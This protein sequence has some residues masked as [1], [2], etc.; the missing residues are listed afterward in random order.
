MDYKLAALELR[1]LAA[2][3]SCPAVV[4][5]AALALADLHDGRAKENILEL[6]ALLDIQKADGLPA[7][8]KSLLEGLQKVQDWHSE[9]VWLAGRA[10][11]TL[12]AV[13]ETAKQKGV[14]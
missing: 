11:V 9:M 7:R 4:A 1:M 12:K 8:G 10:I 14:Q 2:L 3:P 13:V 6:E 5:T